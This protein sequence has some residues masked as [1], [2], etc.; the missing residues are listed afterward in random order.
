M[1]A[2]PG[3]NITGDAII[4]RE[5]EITDIW[6]KLEKQ[7][8]ILTAE[9]RV[10]KTCILRKMGEQPRNKWTPLT[11]WVEQCSHPIECVEKIYDQAS[12]MEVQ[13]TKG[14]WLKRIRSGYK[15]IAG[16]EVAGWKIPSIMSDWK[17]LLS[18]L[19]EDVAQNT[20]NKILVIMD[21]FPLMVAKIISNTKEAGPVVAMDFVD[22]LRAICHQFEPTNQIRFVLSGSIGYHLVLESLRINHEYKSN[23]KSD[24]S[25]YVLDGMCE[26]DVGLMCQKYLDEEDIRRE[27]PAEFVKR[28]C[29]LTD[30][31]PLYIQH[32]CSHFQ[33]TKRTE[34]SPDDIDRTVRELLDNRTIE[35]FA[36]AAKRIENYYK[37]LRLDHMANCVLKM[38]CHEEDYVV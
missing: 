22:T 15:R 7:S 19:I 34:V 3:G 2:N 5:T 24:M 10:G 25:T 23:P 6:R 35:G 20:G 33:D 30:S 1:E 13:S 18:N 4:G 11:C 8:V 27:H 37:K 17:S 12:L 31:L 26:D 21:E 9:R 36:Y 32:V 29:L 16:T 28:M 14:A 38:L